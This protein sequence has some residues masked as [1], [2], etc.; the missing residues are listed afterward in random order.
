LTSSI[1]IIDTMAL[2]KPR[3][4]AAY[5]LSGKERALIDTGYPSSAA[6]I[7]NDLKAA[8]V[9][10]IDYLLP[11]HVHLDH[12]GSCGALAKKFPDSKIHTHPI[13]TKHLVDPSRLI[14]GARDL[15]GEESMRRFGLPEPISAKR[16]HSLADEEI[17]DLGKGLT[18]RTVWTPGHASH[19]LSFLIEP[20]RAFFTG[21][22]V[23]V[24]CPDT[25]ALIPATPPPSFN[26][27]E[28]LASISK[29]RLLKPSELCTPHF[30]QLRHPTA[31]LDANCQKLLEWKT[32]IE[33]S[34]SLGRS[35]ESIA[36]ELSSKISDQLSIPLPSH[37]QTL[38]RVNTTGFAR[39]LRYSQPSAGASHGSAST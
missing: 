9:N 30:G 8:R 19:H 28:A 26:L 13:G 6:E 32:V 37:L 17:I 15:F 3:Y 34:L 20:T 27:D 12:C 14:E 1:S 25:P 38:I 16:V 36:E 11:T 39:W 23:G 5:L 4:V 18:L 24:Y 7:I 22:C 35:I 31:W 29:V 2:G 33:H 10:D 21:D